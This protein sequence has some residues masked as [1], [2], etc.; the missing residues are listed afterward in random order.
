[1]VKQMA[2]Q[3]DVTCVAC[4][5]LPRELSRPKL[6][7]RTTKRYEQMAVHAATAQHSTAQHKAQHGTTLIALIGLSTALYKI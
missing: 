4:L 5:C 1:M 3:S 7:I 6:S 2:A